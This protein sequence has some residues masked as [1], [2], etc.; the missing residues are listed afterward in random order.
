MQTGPVFKKVILTALVLCLFCISPFASASLYD[1]QVT[2][3]MTL[4]M[5]EVPSETPMDF[6]TISRQIV[7][8]SRTYDVDPLLILAII[9]VESRFRP[10]VRSQTGAIGLMQVMPIVI[11]EVGQ[12]VSI[13]K[14]SDLY[15]PTKNLLLGIHYFTYLMEKYGN[16]MKRAL[17]AYN[18]GPSALDERLSRQRLIPLSYYRKVMQYYK[19]FQ[20]KAQTHIETT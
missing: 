4:I 1:R 6:L 2:R 16:D 17:V 10:A 15:D 11:R 19:A 7:S 12:E 20:E 18:L 8:L 13:H 5:D 9:K 14:R 3:V